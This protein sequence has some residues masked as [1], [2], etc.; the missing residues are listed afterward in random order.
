M[1]FSSARASLVEIEQ[2][3]KEEEHLIRAY[4]E[5]LVLLKKLEEDKG[6]ENCQEDNSISDGDILPSLT[7]DGVNNN[8][9]LG[10]TLGSSVEAPQQEER[11]EESSCHEDRQK[12]DEFFLNIQ[13]AIRGFRFTAARQMTSLSS[14]QIL[15]RPLA[16]ASAENFDVSVSKTNSYQFKGYFLSEPTVHASFLM[17]FEMTNERSSENNTANNRISRLQCEISSTSH[18]EEDLS[19]L[20]LQTEMLLEEDKT[21]LPA[22]IDVVSGYLA[23]DKRRKKCLSRWKEQRPDIQF[24][25]TNQKSK[26]LL[27][28]SMTAKDEDNDKNCSN[29]T[30]LSIAWGWK[31]KQNCDGLYL[32]K[33]KVECLEQ[34]DLDSLVKVC[35]GCKQALRFLMP[36]R[37]ND[38]DISFHLLRDPR[39]AK[40]RR[41]VDDEDYDIAE[42]S[43][44]DNKSDNDDSDDGHVLSNYELMRLERI[45]RNE[46]YLAQLGLGGNNKTS[47]PATK[48]K[49]YN[50]K[51][52]KRKKRRSSS[53]LLTKEP[54]DENVDMNL[55]SDASSR[56]ENHR[57][58]LVGQSLLERL[59]MFEDKK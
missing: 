11:E 30:T 23:F 36:K 2:A 19:W 4:Q 18:S 32:I 8:K 50:K 12:N 14:T 47:M 44:S 7:M 37:M 20:Q 34:P 22:W 17:E 42:S 25:F 46:E 54:H 3:I 10:S 59:A 41:I 6:E 16:M 29:P 5:E 9:A 43:D 28:F 21:N 13:A 51:G 53:R 31:W 57:T 55:D 1:A 48:K 40:R 26:S 56:G 24:K 58:N 38:N 52:S 15:E 45:K 39:P 33:P 27:E 49:K 35:G